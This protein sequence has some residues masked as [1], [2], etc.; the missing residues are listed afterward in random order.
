MFTDRARRVVVLAQ[1]EARVFG[2][3]QIDTEHLLLGLMHEDEGVAAQVLKTLGFSIQSLRE[4][5]EVRLGHNPNITLPNLIPFSPT[6]K[7][8]LE[9]SLEAAR[10]LGHNYIGTEHLLLGLTVEEEE[11]GAQILKTAGA[12][13]DWVL[14][15]VVAVLAQYTAPQPAPSPRLLDSLTRNLNAEVAEQL[16][17]TVV[18][19]RPE[20]ERV[21]R[22]LN[23]QTR[24]VP[25]LVGAPGIGKTSVVIGLAEALVLGNVPA[26]FRGRTVRL[27]DVGALFTDPQHHG[28]FTELMA[29]LVSDIQRA[30]GLVLFLDNALTVVQTRQGRSEALAF[31]RPAFGMPGVSVIAATTTAEYRRWERDPGLD[32]LIRPIVLNEP[33]A[34]EVMEILR[35]TARRLEAHHGVTIADDA[36]EAAAALAHDH[37]PDQALPGA[38]LDLLDEAA[39]LVRDSPGPEGKAVP[40]VTHA[41]VAEAAQASAPFHDSPRASPVSPPVPHDPTIWA[42]S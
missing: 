3:E 37:L 13:H 25:L 41:T 24:N 33:P 5:V 28:R 27:L 17:D 42:M 6:A 14:A 30:T 10:G 15:E 16:V 11:G 2:H 29:E 4:I 34:D 32:Q 36:L 8:A 39:T 38:A 20:I 7:K 9:R 35:S 18:G 1:E 22:A 31:F 23:R 26:E 19:R 40:T 21:L 12:D